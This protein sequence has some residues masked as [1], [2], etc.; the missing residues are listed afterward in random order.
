MVDDDLLPLNINEAVLTRCVPLQALLDHGDLSGGHKLGHSFA[1]KDLGVGVFVDFV[2]LGHRFDKIAIGFGGEPIPRLA[3]LGPADVE[4]VGI[5]LAVDV[6]YGHGGTSIRWS[7]L[8]QYNQRHG[9]YEP[10]V[11]SSG[12]SS[13]SC[14]WQRSSSVQ[15]GGLTWQPRSMCSD[16]ACYSMMNQPVDRGSGRSQACSECS[17]ID[18][19]NGSALNPSHTPGSTSSRRMSR[20]ST[21]SLKP[22]NGNFRDTSRSSWLR[23]ISRVAAGWNL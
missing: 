8:C 21:A 2:P 18:D 11:S 7:R 6:G 12:W 20:S 3:S 14:R 17:G 10:C 13:L 9:F 19:E 5:S 22:T 23:S 16:G 4:V 1:E 15:Q